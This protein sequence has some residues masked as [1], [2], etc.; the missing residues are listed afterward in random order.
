MG[1]F[2]TLLLISVLSYK[3]YRQKQQLQQQHITDL[4]KENHCLPQKQ[5]CR[6]RKKNAADLL[7]TYMTALVECY[8]AS[9][10]L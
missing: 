7:K 10:L 2:G 8:P 5:C 1:A 3:N 6:D 9:I 4:E